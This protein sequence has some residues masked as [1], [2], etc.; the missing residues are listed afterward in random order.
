[1]YFFRILF[2]TLCSFYFLTSL[3][4]QCTD[5]YNVI[6]AQDGSG[7]F[8]TIQEAI[9]S[10]PGSGP[11][12]YTIYIKNGV[13]D[14]KLFFEKSYISLIGEDRDSTIIT[15][16][17]L[18]RLW[19]EENGDDWGAATVNIRNN[20]TDLTFA[21]MTI[22]N[23]YADFAPPELDK[24]N[25]HTFT[26]RGGGHRI[27][28]VNCNILSTGGDTVSLWNTAGGM[29]YHK[30]CFINGYVDFIAPRGYCYM[31]D[32]NFFGYNSTASI[33]HD[34][35]GGEDHK[36]VIKNGYFDGVTGF[37]LGRHHRDAQF[38]LIDCYF[39]EEMKN[40]EIY[41]EARDE[42]QW[43]PDRKYYYNCHRPKFDWPWF[44]DNLHEAPGNPAP[45][46]INAYWTFNGEWDP[47]S[48]LEDLLPM[49]FLP[50]PEN[51]QCFPTDGKLS[52]IPGRCATEHLLYLGENNQLEFVGAL[53]EAE[54][55][56]TNLKESTKYYWRVDEISGSDTIKGEVWNF[57]TE[58]TSDL[59]P[60]P[61]YN[62][63]PVQDGDY[64]G[65]LVRLEWDYDPCTVDSFRV[66]FGKGA[67]ERM[68]FKVTQKYNYYL[69]T[70]RKQDT[71]YFWR[72]D[73]V[74]EF[75]TT[76]GP[77][78]NYV[79]EPSTSG[80][81]VP[82]YKNFKILNASPNPFQSSC[83]IQYEIPFAGK[84]EIRISDVAGKI[85]HQKIFNHHQIGPSTYSI[86]K[87]NQTGLLFC[88][89][90]LEKDQR[91]IKIVSQ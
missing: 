20:V 22:Q 87:L 36:L 18:R 6:V 49:A 72:I 9:D 60:N 69:P 12:F 5:F 44:R 61:V 3:K 63:S 52:W 86:P 58:K 41:W 26:F 59:K 79:Y 32:C 39:T 27:I 4:A 67:A 82:I 13:Y 29:F 14:E 66:Y 15:T 76:E 62:P 24:P 11:E 53:N 47:E 78:W 83:D 43:S 33:W 55:N 64:F 34:G 84:V 68:E 74:N 65:S 77:V 73:A 80:F 23:N 88:K 81:F 16:A 7:D 40:Q 71:T 31:E 28:T 46:D 30:S 37:A 85:V 70:S 35:S 17:V 19:I 21:N 8:N 54:Y 51:D 2:F 1:M 56:L 38:F 90:S 48:L 91:I 10:A 75:G 25:D 45:E 57:R 89:I 42:I 50:S